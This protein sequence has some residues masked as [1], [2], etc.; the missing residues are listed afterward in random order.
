[1]GFPQSE[2]PE[3]RLQIDPNDFLAPQVFDPKDERWE[4]RGKSSRLPDQCR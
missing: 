2:C 3:F 1:M 4:E